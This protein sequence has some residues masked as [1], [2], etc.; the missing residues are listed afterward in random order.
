VD[1]WRSRPA[2]RSLANRGILVI[3]IEADHL[4]FDW[5][6]EYPDRQT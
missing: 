2:E 3:A 1:E 4:P 5:S 6:R